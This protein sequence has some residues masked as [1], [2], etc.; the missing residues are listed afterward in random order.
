[1]KLTISELEKISAELF[2]INRSLTGKGNETTLDILNRAGCGLERLYVASGEKVFDWTVPDEWWINRGYIKNKY[3]ETVVDFED[4]NLHVVSYSEPVHLTGVKKEYLLKKIHTSDKGD[5]IIPYRTSYYKKDWGFCCSAETLSSEQFVEPFEVVIESGFNPNGNLVWGERLFEGSQ[6]KEFILTTY[7]CHPS[8]ANDNLSGILTNLAIIKK[9]E[10]QPKKRFSYRFAFFPETIGALCFLNSHC[11]IAQILGGAVISNTAGPGS[12]K[13]KESFDPT[14]FTNFALSHV[15]A[16]KIDLDVVPF[17]PDGSDERQFSTPGFRINTPS[18]H[19]SKYY[20]FVE[21]H[22]SADDLG[23]LD[24]DAIDLIS[25]IY[26]D[27]INLVDTF[28]YPAFTES[29]G[30]I[31]L[32]KRGLYPEIGGGLNQNNDDFDVEREIEIM[33]WMM[34]EFDGSISN[35]EFA[36]KRGFDIQSVN[37]IIEKLSNA[38]ILKID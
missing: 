15:A 33:S 38:G 29:R 28:C 19:K 17:S 9:L 18:L 32:G 20:D 7:I 26:I 30:E 31:Q 27:W 14:H 4:S 13:M 5:S 6:K 36:S 34:H 37:G 3:G 35:F 1:M 12:F 25:D 24:L 2:P 11:D 10:M 23:I 21:Y 16:S 8:M 22:T